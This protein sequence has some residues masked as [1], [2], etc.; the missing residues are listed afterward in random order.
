M[1]QNL[2]GGRTAKDY[3]RGEAPPHDSYE[4][5]GVAKP[6]EPKKPPA[7]QQIPV[8]VAT[9]RETVVLEAKPKKWKYLGIGAAIGAL[10]TYFGV[11]RS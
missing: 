3:A 4:W 2:F 8:V 6:P 9:M 1:A 7:R 11:R 5:V 10:L